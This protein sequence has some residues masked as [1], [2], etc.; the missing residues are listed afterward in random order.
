MNESQL[1]G[2][3]VGDVSRS[4][5]NV[6][7]ADQ[8]D[9]EMYENQLNGLC[10]RHERRTDDGDQLNHADPAVH[11]NGEHHLNGTSD[12]DEPPEIE[13][14]AVQPKIE[15]LLAKNTEMLGAALAPKTGDGEKIVFKLLNSKKFPKP[16]QANEY[17]L[18]KREN[19]VVSG[20]IPFLESVTHYGLEIVKI[21]YII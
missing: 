8:S 13:F 15:P 17:G 19:D 7:E 11:K 16:M 21:I 20:N 6:T 1:S 4:D 5:G 9:N 10:V 18:I 2:L 12:D 3:D 14:I